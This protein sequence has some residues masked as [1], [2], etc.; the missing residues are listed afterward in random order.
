MAF[1]E[2]GFVALGYFI[3]PAENR[4]ESRFVTLS[5]FFLAVNKN[6]R[7]LEIELAIFLKP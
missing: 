5:R 4:K 6:L 1:P 7:G 3:L 2:I